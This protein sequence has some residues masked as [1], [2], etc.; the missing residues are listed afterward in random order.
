MKERK[1]LITLAESKEEALSDFAG[2]IENSDLVLVK[3]SIRNLSDVEIDSDVFNIV[4]FD[5][6]LP[7]DFDGWYAIDATTDMSYEDWCDGIERV[8]LEDY[9]NGIR[10]I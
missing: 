8:S 6:E 4:E 5:S 3:D 1:V 2:Y 9:Q 10:V 7:E